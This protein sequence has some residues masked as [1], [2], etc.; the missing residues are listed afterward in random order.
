MLEGLQNGNNLV[1][2]AVI[3]YR[4]TQAV[5]L[6]FVYDGRKTGI[7]KPVHSGRAELRAIF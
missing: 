2:N 3:E 5:L 4:V 1:W 7:A 6:T